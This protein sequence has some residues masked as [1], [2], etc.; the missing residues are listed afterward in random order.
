[1][2]WTD[3][4]L[5][6]LAGAVTAGALLLTVVALVLHVAWD[7]RVEDLRPL[8]A[9]DVVLATLY[10]LAGLLVLWHRPRNAAGWVLLSAALVAVSLLAHQ[11][12]EIGLR[13]QGSL[14]LVP[15][16]IWLSAWTFVPYW[17]Q[18]SLLPA[19]FPDGRLPSPAWR[20]YV[21][22][23]MAL[24]AV[25]VVSAM[26]KVDEDVEGQGGTNPLG[27]YWLFERL[28]TWTGPVL[29]YGSGL[30]LWLVCSPIAV[31]GLLRRQRAASGVER[32]Q[33]QWLLL[34][35]T[36]CVVLTVTDA[37]AVVGG[38]S[39]VLFAAG[40]ALVPLSVAIAV[41]RHGL[42][43]VDVVVNRTVVYALLTGAGL[44]SYVALVAV[45]GRYVGSDG[46]GPV[47]AAL[48]VAAAAAGRAR[49]Q[50][51]VDRRLFG[52]RRDPYAVVQQV[53]ASTAAAQAPAAALTALVESVRDAL[54]LPFVQVLDEVGGVA[55][56]AGAPWLAPTSCPSSTRGGRWGCSS[57]AGGR[58]R[59]GCAA[60]RRR[61]WST[62]RTAPTGCCR[63]S[64]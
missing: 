19:L 13:E 17:A 52:A 1:V 43:D 7:S 44:L 10:P 41:L 45:A 27:Q 26:L 51:L 6:A 57:S 30:V 16:A 8:H 48:V 18:P 61:R 33:L 2:V 15:L 50:A 31:A 56:E 47:V 20:R 9:G 23:A 35:L 53:G 28:P 49:L 32:T 24:L 25:L 42:F 63:R 58:A 3:R 11:W 14:P 59:S 29:Q 39:D 60:R 40:F 4:R 64:G 46:S 38:S 55:A 12:Y 36:G 62:W 21:Q 54:R 37:D 5:R 34:G 22:V